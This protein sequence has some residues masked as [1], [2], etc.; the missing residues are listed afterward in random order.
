MAWSTEEEHC[1]CFKNDYPAIFYNKECYRR[2]KDKTK[3]ERAMSRLQTSEVQVG[4]QAAL[5]KTPAVK[6]RC[7]H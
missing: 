4:V 2:F 5:K 6:L 3:I 7:H 1:L